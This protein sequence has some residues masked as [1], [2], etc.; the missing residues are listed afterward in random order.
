[1][2][3]IMV[4]CPVAARWWILPDW[5]NAVAEACA[6]ADMEPHYVFVV[7]QDDQPTIEVIARET[8][9]RGA[10]VDTMVT[11]ENVMNAQRDWYRESRLRDMAELRNTLLGMVRE[12][13]PTYFWSLDSDMIPKPDALANALSALPG[14]AA[15]GMRAFMTMTGLDYTSRAQFI[16]GQ[17]RNRADT[18]GT[19]GVDIVM[20][21]VL[22]TPPAYDVDYAYHAHGEDIGWSLAAALAGLK[23]G[24]TSTA[25]CTHVMASSY[26]GWTDPRV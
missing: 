23:L 4:G 21:A 2:T 9:T 20:A 8:E 7:P 19:F 6:R 24:W 5:F 3:E 10:R 26:L 16:K 17:L 13:R 1:M 22:M 12:I 15:M 11:A 14:F 25:S 18:V